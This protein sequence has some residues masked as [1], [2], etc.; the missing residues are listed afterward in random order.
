MKQATPISLRSRHRLQASLLPVAALLMLA[1]GCDQRTPAAK[2][3]EKGTIQLEALNASGSTPAPEATRQ[4]TYTDVVSI[5]NGATSGS[6]GELAAAKLLIA[7]AQRGL[8]EAPA[9]AAVQAE[10]KQRALINLTEVS[11]GNW[12]SSNASADAAAAFDVSKQLGE[13]ASSK[14]DR[15]KE[16]SQATTRK[17]NLQKKIADLRSLAKAKL[18]QADAKQ[19]EYVKQMASTQQMDAVAAT[20]VVE[21]A[22]KVRREGDQLRL[23]GSTISAQADLV[24]PELADAT[25]QLEKATKQRA[26]LDDI[27]KSLNARLAAAQKEAADM[28]SLAQN[29]AGEIDKGV[30]DIEA[31]RAGDLATN[32]SKTLDALKKALSAA[33]EAQQEGGPSAKMSMGLA[34]I[35]MAETL[36]A[37]AQ[38]TQA[39]ATLLDELA[40]APHALPNA[41]TYA[42]KL[43][44]VQKEYADLMTQTSDAFQAAQTAVQGV[45]VQDKS[46]TERLDKLKELLE[47]ATKYLKGEEKDLSAAFKIQAQSATMAATGADAPS[48]APAGD[49]TAAVRAAVANYINVAKS[50]NA[51]ALAA[52]SN[53]SSAPA[54]NVLLDVSKATAKADA[55]CRAKF[56]K[57]Y[58]DVISTIPGI[59]SMAAQMAAAQFAAISAI[60]ASKLD[61]QIAGDKARVT[62]A[63]MPQPISLVKVGQSWVIDVLAFANSV[64]LPAPQAK[65]I[66]IFGTALNGWADDINSGKFA[67]ATAASQGF[68]S[69]IQP[70]MAE[71]QKMTPGG[72]GG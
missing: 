41:S 28:R 70:M 44:A 5:A 27:E 66:G 67:D 61:I 13:I 22:N 39:F 50:G 17:N 33:K 1:G 37:R 24:E 25:A 12:N 63:G 4:K 14:L 6:P 54:G 30:S 7:S 56:Q 2:A 23:E 21:A 32:Y 19:A 55:A 15:E 26:D 40:H 47:G 36:W 43:E 68:V 58:T 31:I 65:V 49:E 48:A 69:R 16:I 45:R 18:E 11:L 46:V 59:G 42:T 71:M 52:I 3:V 53:L 35:D 29:A 57:S 10:G 8:S 20:P 34:Q 64:Q 72:G 60:D 38:G 9:L 62:G 51:S